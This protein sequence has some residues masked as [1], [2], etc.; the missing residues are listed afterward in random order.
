MVWVTVCRLPQQ[1]LTSVRRDEGTPSPLAKLQ[2]AAVFPAYV[3]LFGYVSPQPVRQTSIYLSVSFFSFLPCVI[4]VRYGQNINSA[5]LFWG[6]LYIIHIKIYPR[7]RK[8]FMILFW[9]YQS[10]ILRDTFYAPLPLFL[11][12]LPLPNL[13]LSLVLPLSLSSPHSSHP[14]TA[15]W[16]SFIVLF[17]FPYIQPC[18]SHSQFRTSLLK[19]FS[20]L[21]SLS[22]RNPLKDIGSC[23]CTFC[24]FLHRVQTFAL[25]SG[26]QKRW[27]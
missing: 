8:K 14:H 19:P 13:S 11:T 1:S 4:T 6:S 25:D 23:I 10:V 7:V 17:S 15:L 16:V 18:S 21:L 2:S 22:Y 3:H 12:C 26:R 24:C 20:F 9:F 5:C 27:S